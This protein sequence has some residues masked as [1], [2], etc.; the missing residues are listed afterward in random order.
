MRTK[1]VSLAI[2]AG[3]ALTLLPIALLT[4]QA[5]APA[6]LSGQVASSEE[7]AMEGVLVS[8]KKD[9]SAITVTVVSDSQGN[10]SFPASKLEPG[11]YSIRIRAIG[12]DLDR[13]A[14]VAVPAQQPAKLDLKLRKTE[15]L[16][17]QMSNG[18]WLTSFPGTD[19][20]KNAMLGCIGC[21]TLE[22]V[23]RSTH[24]PDD[25]INVTLPRMQGYVNQSIPAAPQLRKGERR[26]EERGD[27]RVQVYR[28]AADFLSRVNLSSGP[29]WTFALKTLPRPKGRAT[30]VVITEYDLPRE[31]IQPHDVVLDADGIAWYSSFGEQFLGRL[32]PKTGK[33]TEY[34][35]P[36]HKPGFPTGF[37]GL[38]VDKA[39]D[40]WLG[41]MYQATIVKFER[42]TETFKYWTLP[43]EQNIDAAQVNMVSPQF[44][45]VDGK[46]WSQ[47]NGFAGV[48]RLDLAT[49]K[50][51]TWE[52]FKDAPKGEPHNI[53]DVVPD[54][55][56]NAFFTDFRQKHIGR[57]DAKTGEV[58][59][60]AILTPNPALRRG[61][62]DAQDR[63]WFGEY[64][65]DKIGVFDTRTER[66]TEWAMP[67]R[68]TNP[69]DVV[70]DKN[71]EAWTGSMLNDRVVR[72][73]TRSGEFTEYLLPRST[74]I[75]RVFVDNSTSP[76][77]FWVGSN[78][79][80]SIIKL[81]PLD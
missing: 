65:G 45:H 29:Q 56:N 55:Q 47:N 34:P 43:A 77:T 63:L 48:H 37:L 62:M 66:F 31:T 24:K 23:A 46:V 51:E 80:A 68:W 49:G 71:D 75:R 27:Q 18:E 59:L 19:Q 69:Y 61:Q 13:P 17:A 42:K 74:N 53:Y 58:K 25:F 39:G 35:V 30:R 2:S 73:D 36:M 5:Q 26:M 32:D 70:L 50:I 6:A 20:Q 64:R 4:A 10:Y 12:Y 76:V 40:L 41:N 67:T 79:G 1:N 11:Q 38:R 15:D 81:E 72:L 33:A 28:A 8:A 7:G 22:R 9:G 60:F 54:S 3:L 14:A 57:I 78:H 44:S 52:P 16:A 21:H